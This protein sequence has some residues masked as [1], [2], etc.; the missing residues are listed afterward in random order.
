[1][2][3]NE[4]FEYNVFKD[5]RGGELLELYRA[6]KSDR[7]PFTL[8]TTDVAQFYKSKSEGAI[9][10]KALKKLESYTLA[11]QSY[12]KWLVIY[13]NEFRLILPSNPKNKQTKGAFRDYLEIYTMMDSL[14]HVMQSCIP[15]E[16]ST[17]FKHPVWTDIEKKFG[18]FMARKIDLD[19]FLDSVN[20]LKL[21]D[22]NYFELSESLA[23]LFMVDG[24]TFYVQVPGLSE[25][26]DTSIPA[27]ERFAIFIS[28]LCVRLVL[29][30]VHDH[31]C[32]DVGA[33]QGIMNNIASFSSQRFRQVVKSLEI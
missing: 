26:V 13:A 20:S 16:L 19:A 15:D 31:M 18:E 7:S 33:A 25:P 9:N 24:P 21:C 2:S 3:A 1:M 27:G 32:C 6:F 11:Q 8:L 5:G 23:E 12:V 30:R 29:D 14:L 28:M 4:L 17:N 10:P 22:G